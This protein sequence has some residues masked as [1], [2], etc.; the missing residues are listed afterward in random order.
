VK[1]LVELDR[2]TMYAKE[3]DVNRLKREA[4]ELRDYLLAMPV[5]QDR[6]RLREQ[7]LPFCDAALA[8]TLRLP[9]DVADKPINITRILD[10]DGYIPPGFEELYARFM[11]TAV[12]SRADSQ[13]PVERDG[14]LWALMEFEG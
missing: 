13:H 7:V 2:E 10:R 9:I 3:V 12:G 14:K 4:R 6:E 8:G 1:R 5:E 11:N